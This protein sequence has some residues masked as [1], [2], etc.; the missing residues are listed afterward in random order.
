MPDA[1]R[2]VSG[3]AG[4]AFGLWRGRALDGLA[5]ERRLRREW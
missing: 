5:Y 2:R 1:V 3:D 4:R